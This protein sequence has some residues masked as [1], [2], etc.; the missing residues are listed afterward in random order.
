[1][2]GR[3]SRAIFVLGIYSWLWWSTWI[4]ELFVFLSYTKYM[5]KVK[6]MYRFKTQ[7]PNDNCMSQLNLYIFVNML[8]YTNSRAQSHTS[9]RNKWIPCSDP[10]K[11]FTHSPQT[12]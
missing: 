2:E 1:M 12:K 8:T 5:T 4:F 6:E 9:R 10:A 7:F 11:I 3:L